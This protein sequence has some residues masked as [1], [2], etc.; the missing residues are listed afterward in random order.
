MTSENGQDLDQQ[1]ALLLLMIQQQPPLLPPPRLALHPL[2]PHTLRFGEVESGRST[3]SAEPGPK[4]L[5]VPC[6]ED[7]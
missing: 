6:L 1:S 2:L 7:K 3:R 4:Y 5:S